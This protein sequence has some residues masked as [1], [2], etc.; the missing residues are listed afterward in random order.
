LA[1]EF[2]DE[3]TL[4]KKVKKI[5]RAHEGEEGC[6]IFDG[7]VIEKPSMD[8]NDIICWHFDH[9]ENKAVKGINLLSAFYHGTKGGQTVRLPIGYRIIAKTEEYRD[10][11]SGEEK[12]KSP[13]IKNGMMREMIKRHIQSQVKFSY[14][15]AGSRHSSAE[16]MRFTAKRNKVF[17]FELKENRQ[18]TG[19]EKKRDRGRFG[20]LDQL[21]V[22]EE[23][24]AGVWIKDLEFPVRIFKQVFRNRDGTGGRRFLASNDL[25]LTGGRFIT[26]YKKRRGAA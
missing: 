8:G 18:V 10:Q 21:K 3:K 19:S 13:V 4:W 5:V 17:I 26:L 15:L 22:P 7:T 24:P 14:I 16:N 12:R 25:T 11:K 20:R 9:K 2:F 1:S 6:L 23:R